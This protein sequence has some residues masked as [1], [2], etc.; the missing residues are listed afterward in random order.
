MTT[1]IMK[2]AINAKRATRELVRGVGRILD[3]SGSYTNSMRRKYVTEDSLVIDTNSLRSDWERVGD[4]IRTSISRF[5]E[6][7]G[8]ER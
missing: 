6:E 2:D 1:H 5:K 8:E 4:D 7:H 3:I